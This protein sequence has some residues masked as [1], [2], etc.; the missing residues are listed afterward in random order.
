MGGPY[1]SWMLLRVLRVLR[2]SVPRVSRID[3]RRQKMLAGLEGVCFFVTKGL[4]HGLKVLHAFVIP[5][6][7]TP[8]R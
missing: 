4:L 8:F 5:S 2:G 1:E 7:S 6:I 3:S